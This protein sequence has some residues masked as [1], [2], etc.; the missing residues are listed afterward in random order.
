MKKLFA[1]TTLLLLTGTYCYSQSSY[2]KKIVFEKDTCIAI[3]IS[4]LYSLNLKLERKR[5][6][7]NQIGI[8]NTQNQEYSRLIYNYKQ[9]ILSR[10]SL[11]VGYKQAAGQS[12]QFLLEEF[13]DKKILQK[14]LSNRKRKDHIMYGIIGALSLVFFLK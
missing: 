3:S 14:K 9:Q 4:Q 1:I 8:V 10:D 13:E 7:E 12:E 6:I 5:F 11:I 2:P